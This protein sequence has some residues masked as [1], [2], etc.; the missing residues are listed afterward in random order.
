MA[1]YHLNSK[2][3]VATLCTAKIKCRLKNG[4]IDHYPNKEEAQSAF[5]RSQSISKALKPLKREKET[6]LI[7]HG[8]KIAEKDELNNEENY[9]PMPSL[10]VRYIEDNFSIVTDDALMK[11]DEKFSAAKESSSN[12]MKDFERT[13]TT[14]SG[15][16]NHVFSFKEG[17]GSLNLT[18]NFS[19]SDDLDGD[20][21][22]GDLT[23]DSNTARALVE[24][25]PS[26]AYIN[27]DCAVL[28]HDL[29]ASC[30]EYVDDIAEIWETGELWEKGEYGDSV[31]VIAKLKDGSYIDGLGHWSPSGLTNFWKDVSNDYGSQIRFSDSEIETKP[32]AEP[33]TASGKVL[34]EYLQ[35]V[36]G[37]K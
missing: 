2:T 33:E 13:F 37:K 24:K 11:Y 15:R 31:H 12:A 29:W 8:L 10:K 9:R 3:G 14:K 7:S 25:D 6:C 21:N 34:K 4:N 27:G 1:K 16:F 22:F 5:E 17:R 30:P 28:A 23:Q 19:H 26:L 18:G 32:Y 20:Y 35:K 36:Y